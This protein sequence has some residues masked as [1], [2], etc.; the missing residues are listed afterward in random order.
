MKRALSLL[1]LVLGP[2]ASPSA[3]NRAHF[4]D[5]E[6]T[7]PLSNV[8]LDAGR[9]GSTRIEGAL[10]AGEQRRISVPVPLDSFVARTEPILRFEH[11]AD[12]LTARGR[13]RFLGWSRD[14]ATLSVLPAGLRA[15]A[16]PALEGT[17]V[18]VSRAAP[19]VL[20]AS[21][22]IALALRRR[23][24]LALL[25]SIAA[26][27]ALIPLVA[28]PAR[29]ADAAV[30]LYD[31]DDGGAWRR[32]D[33]AFDQIA[34]PEGTDAFELQS[35][36][37]SAPITWHVPLDPSRPTH[38]GS[39]GARLF[40]ASVLDAGP[41]RMTRERNGFAPLAAT[42]LREDG[43]WSE[44]GAWALDAR[45]PDAVGSG[46]PPGWLASNLPQGVPILI[47]REAPVAGRPTVWVRISGL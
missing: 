15:R 36:P 4:A 37:A 27:A 3:Q 31:G 32:V 17:E 42:W 39:R 26:A 43:A 45:L 7:G 19:L 6:L 38:A 21:L 2:I 20:V 12:D 16:L 18:R 40:V 34:V 28:A 5:V 46:S 22:V 1:I 10:M 9:L 13:A 44:R 41:G 33:A 35:D 25:A 47:A 30:T 23:P 8:V 11:D 24:W 29:A 14:R